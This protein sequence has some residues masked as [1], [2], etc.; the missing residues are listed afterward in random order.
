M[1]LQVLLPFIGYFI[2]IIGI[3]IYA[4]RFS[5]KGISEFFLGGRSMNRF[6]VALSAVVS[7]RSAWLIL[8]VSGL[9]FNL[10][11]QA[12]WAILGYTFIEFLLFI[13]YAPRLRKYTEEKECITIPDF[14][15]ARFNDKNGFLRGLIVLIFL[16]FMVSYVAAQFASGGKAFFA[17]FNITHTQGLLIT[18]AIVLLYTLLGGFMAVSYID[19][20]QGFMMILA[21]VI[22]PITGIVAF[23]GW[24]AISEAALPSPGYLKLN[25][26]S[27]ITFI[28]FLGIGLGSPGNPHILVRYMSINDPKQFT[29][30]AVVGTFWNLI[31]GIGAVLIGIVGRAYFS[32]VTQLPGADTENIFIALANQ[33]MHPV[34]VG[35][36]LAAVFA[37]IMS[38]ADSQLL[39][40]ASSIVRDLYE[41]I[42]RKGSQVS[43]RELTIYSR[44]SVILLVGLAVLLSLFSRDLIFWFVLFAWAGL[45]A[46][47]G[48]TSILALFWKGT[49][50]SGVIAGLLAG[51]VTVIIWKSNAYL[52]NLLYELIPAFLFSLTTTFIVSLIEK[53]LSSK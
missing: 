44:L 36:I 4:T 52:D 46:A 38:T 9:A 42:I 33:L 27:A 24:E 25:A 14:Y 22:L 53:K 50:K 34:L 43:P 6:V 49:T 8:G 18:A 26:L 35:L 1:N 19:V 47:I 29:W 37:A 3:G 12:I 30:T 31:M 39:V 41:K 17:H 48:P 16:I 13:F 7:G 5:S 45:G 11:I 2:L 23:G 15:A 20:V 28:G 21:L 51:T 32:E 40:A 10:G